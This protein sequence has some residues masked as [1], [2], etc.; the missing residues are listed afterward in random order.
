MC[1][2]QLHN[3]KQVPCEWSIKRP[4]VESVKTKDWTFFACEP[5]DGTL[6]PGA[7]TNLKVTFTPAMGREAPYSLCLPI[8]VANN[9]RV[10]ELVCTAKGYTPKVGCMD[11]GYIRCGSVYLVLVVSSTTWY[12]LARCALG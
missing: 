7:R 11:W 10:R 12:V 2:V 3:Q 5:C 4:A 6:E 9:P 1:T 8:K